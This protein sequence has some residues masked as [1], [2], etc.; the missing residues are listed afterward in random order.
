MK[1]ACEGTRLATEHALKGAMVMNVGGGFHHAFS[2]H[3]EGFCVYADGAVAIKDARRCGALAE[4]DKVLMIDLDAHRG[5]GF[6]SIFR[7]DPAVEMFDM[8][9]FQVYPGIY[10]GDMDEFPFIIPLKN[11][12]NDEVYLNALKEELPR[13]MEKNAQPKLVFYNAGSDI[14]AGDNLGNLNVSYDGV[15]ERDRYVI[16]MLAAMNVPTVIMTSGGYTNDSY[17]LVASL[18]SMVIK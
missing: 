15:V 8:Y 18:A 2:D 14:L 5:N 12:V 4:S 9:N 17:K 11:K 13:F 10:E 16:E 1:L 3:G 7:D 6:E